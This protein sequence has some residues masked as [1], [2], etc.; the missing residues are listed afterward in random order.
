MSG[1]IFIIQDAIGDKVRQ[2]IL[3]WFFCLYTKNNQFTNHNIRTEIKPKYP[4][5]LKQT[6][7]P[8]PVC[9]SSYITTY[10]IGE[11]KKFSVVVCN[12]L[13]Y[14]PLS[15]YW[16]CSDGENHRVQITV[17]RRLY[18]CLHLA[19][20]M[21]SPIIPLVIVVGVMFF[22]MSREASHSKAANVVEQTIRSIRTVRL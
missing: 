8:C 6:C 14:F 13:S 21:L 9:L 11:K 19:P 22:F 3:P 12:S 7:W 15:N 5:L 1:R 2:V 20:V 18:Y 16:L 10:Y 17:Y 4:F